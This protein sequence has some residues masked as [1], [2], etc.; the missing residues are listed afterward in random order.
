MACGP[1]EQNSI[2][3]Q[4]HF[5][6]SITRSAF[7]NDEWIEVTTT[8][9][10]NSFSA[11]GA[12]VFMTLVSD[13]GDRRDTELLQSAQ[14]LVEHLES[15]W[16]RFRETSEISQL[17]RGRL[18]ENLSEETRQLLLHAEMASTA[19]DGMFDHRVGNEMIQV[20][21]TS[22]LVSHSLP[23]EKSESESPVT[24]LELSSRSIDVGGI[25]K[26]F[27][28]DLVA[29]FLIDSGANG[30]LVSIGGD[31]RCIGSPDQEQGWTIDV[32]HP[33]GDGVI[34]RLSLDNGG[35]AT[36]YLLARRWNGASPETSHV[37][38][39][40]TGLSID[41]TRAEI[42]Q[43]TVVAGSAAWAEAF[44][45]ACLVSDPSAAVALLDRNGIAGLLVRADG[46]TVH[47][48]NWSIFS[49]SAC[50]RR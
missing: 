7:S 45:T 36:S 8:I 14:D 16:S 17:N 3:C 41:P 35:V 30:A 46:S 44:A 19:T 9:S 34:T 4:H 25:G 15:L 11:M 6:C 40:R 18:P 49:P 21:Y 38:D 50:S 13:L 33:S 2:W 1:L 12:S 20:G 10:R 42:I 29:K 24:T 28:A 27:A 26:G 37:I 31:L 39:P 32:E 23:T 48:S 47:N 5:G 43:A 22:S